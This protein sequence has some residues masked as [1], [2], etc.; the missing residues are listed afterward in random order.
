MT[1]ALLTIKIG[2]NPELG[3]L[4]GLLLTWHGIF[5]ALGIGLGVW[6]GVWFGRKAGFT[7]DD[8]Y[9]IALVGVPA[10]IIG[11]RVLFVLENWSDF[12]GRRLDVF[13]INQGGISLYGALIGA[14]AIALIYGAWKKLPLLRGLDAASF[15]MILGQGIGRVGCLVAGDIIA[16]SS[17]LPFA[18]QYTNVNSPSFG[19]PPMQFVTAYEVLGDFVILGL[20]VAL[21]KFKVFKRDGLLFFTYAALYSAMRF[22]ISFMRLD[23][24]VVLGLRMAQLLALGVIAVSIVAFVL[25]LLHGIRSARRAAPVEPA[26]PS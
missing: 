4:G 23:K 25:I 19:L 24:E 21:W 26:L 13:R 20:L 5:I 22:G 6:L 3:H 17:S 10:G 7:E 16:N 12:A 18:V 9:T 1:D 2:I 8:A 14:V 11:A 15:G